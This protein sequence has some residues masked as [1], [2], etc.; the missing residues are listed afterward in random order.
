MQAESTIPGALQRVAA[1]L[2]DWP[3]PAALVGGVAIVARVRPRFTEDIDVALVVEPGDEPQLL[4]RLEAHGFAYDEVETREFLQGGLVRAWLPP[5]REAGIGLDLMFATDRFFRAV[6]QRATV[7]D[8][9]GVRLPVATVED[10][11]LMKLDAY[12]TVDLDDIISIKDAFERELDMRYVSQQ[13]EHLDVIERL[14]VY[15]DAN[16]D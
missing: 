11:L 10:L 16:E 4:E 13:A 12:R 6:I 15:F 7:L 8:L 2:A 5:S 3:H 1:L 9:G 14:R